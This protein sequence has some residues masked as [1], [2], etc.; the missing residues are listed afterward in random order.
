MEIEPQNHESDELQKPE[1]PLYISEYDDPTALARREVLKGSILGDERIRWTI[2]RRSFRRIGIGTLEAME[3][4]PTPKSALGRIFYT[5]KRFLVGRPIATAQSEHEHLTKIKALSVLSS[6]A[7]SSITYATEAMLFT[8][9]AA[10]SGNLSKALFISFAVVALLIIV[11]SLLSP[12]NP[13]LS[14]WWW[15]LYCGDGKLGDAGWV[16]YC[17]LAD[18]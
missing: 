2:P 7:I 11:I 17:R 4:T 12:D 1:K 8:L 9:M 3:A 6:D 18:D 13:D 5:L 10:G 15:V 14:Q 16:G